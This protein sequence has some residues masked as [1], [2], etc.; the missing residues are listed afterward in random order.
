MP[1][2]PPRLILASGSRYRAELL[3]RLRLSFEAMA[4][5]VDETPHRGE[6]VRALTQ[7]LAL[8]KAR[9]LADAHPGAWVLGSDQAAIAD[10][11]LLGKPGTHARAVEQLQFLSGKKVEFHTAVVLA[12][13]RVLSGADI[14]TVH[15]REL[16]SDEIERYLAAEPA[17]DCAGSFKC[18]GLGITL[19][20]RI[21][22]D[23]PTA[24][25][26]LPLIA[27]RRLLADAGWPLP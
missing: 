6:P 19:F 11:R 9:A 21:E 8:A 3:A 2:S 23:D 17:Y 13:E 27:V 18:E 20:E 26:G 24:L 25:I 7:R 10:G 15:F 14:T 1:A 4:S 16:A 22:S 12:G 5:N